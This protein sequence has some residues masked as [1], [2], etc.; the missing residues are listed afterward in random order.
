MRQNYTRMAQHILSKDPARMAAIE[1]EM[2]QDSADL[3]ETYKSYEATVISEKDKELL[4]APLAARPKYIG[5]RKQALAL[6]QQGKK[7]EAVALI[8]AEVTPAFNVYIAACQ[9]MTD[10]KKV[11]DCLQPIA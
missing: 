7:D 4:A 8:E 3:T 2:N 10:S 5:A 6:S 9:A 1:K 11:P